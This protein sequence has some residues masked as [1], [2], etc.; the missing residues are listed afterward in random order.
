MS[1]VGHCN[2]LFER[3]H[4]APHLHQAGL[5]EVA[6]AVTSG[7]LGAK[8]QIS[9]GEASAGL[10]EAQRILDA[11]DTGPSTPAPARLVDSVVSALA[12]RA[13]SP[14]T[15]DVLL[16]SSQRTG[17]APERGT[18]LVAVSSVPEALVSEL[19]PILT[20]IRRASR[21]AARP[22]TSRSLRSVPSEPLVPSMPSLPT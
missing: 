8:E 3:S 19:D 17:D 15:F 9:V 1:F 14:S 20:T 6:H 12:A 10:G 22:A 7:L 4:A 13:G 21:T 2:D 11:A 16:L 18:N 5:P